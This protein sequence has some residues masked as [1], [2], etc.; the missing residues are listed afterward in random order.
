V[1]L[2]DTSVWVDHLRAGNRAL[3]SLLHDA[4][5][6]THP[7]VI[8]EL[9][10]GQIRNRL[11]ILSLLKTLPVAHAAGHDEVLAFLE[12]HR[13]FGRGIGWIDAHLLASALLSHARLI[14][15][16]RRLS[17]LAARVGVSS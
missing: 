7:F 3:V 11:E 5:V 10:C 1:T 2:V 16:D 13:L 17:S 9:A 14:T 8:G 12:D 6:L 15:L 4:E